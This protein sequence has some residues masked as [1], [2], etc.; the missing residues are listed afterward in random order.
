MVLFGSHDRVSDC[1]GGMEM[2]TGKGRLVPALCL[3]SPLSASAPGAL[4]RA[5]VMIGEENSEE[6]FYQN[7]S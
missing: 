6:L 1:D 3:I 5:S 4:I 2:E 7:L